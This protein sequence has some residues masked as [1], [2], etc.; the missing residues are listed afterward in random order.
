[1][2]VVKFL[3]PKIL[4]NQNLKIIHNFYSREWSRIQEKR[5]KMKFPSFVPPDIKDWAYAGCKDKQTV[6]RPGKSTRTRFNH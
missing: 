2:V 4:E 1:M 5:N 3:H 6:P